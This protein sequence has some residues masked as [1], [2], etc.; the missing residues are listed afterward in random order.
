MYVE[1]DIG[2][3]Q[4][5]VGGVLFQCFFGGIGCYV[6]GMVFQN[7]VVQGGFFIGVQMFWYLFEEFMQQVILVMWQIVCDVV[8]VELCWVY[9]EFGNCFYQI[10]NFLLIGK[11]EEDWCYCVDVLNKG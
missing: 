10:V 6:D 11:G 5:C 9:M 7:G 1:V 2:G 3:V 8:D 4:V